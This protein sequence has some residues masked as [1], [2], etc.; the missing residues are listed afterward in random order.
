MYII[1]KHAHSGLR[2]LILIMLVWAV[3][4]AILKFIKKSEFTPGD[5]RTNI[6]VLSLAHT[7]LILGLILYFI[8][9]KV[10]FG[11]DTMSNSILRFFTVEHISLMI[12]ALVLITIGYSKS[13]KAKTDA[14]KFR[15]IFLFYGIALLL[16]LVA[17][18]WPWMRLASG[19]V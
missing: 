1:L 8:S 6:I 13:K 4:S 10:V 12:I 7:Q 14:K 2:W 16:I 3:F 11:T 19:W 18:P 5:K 17:I 9:P 15:H